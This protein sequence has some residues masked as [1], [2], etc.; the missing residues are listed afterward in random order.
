[1]NDWCQEEGGSHQKQSGETV[2]DPARRMARESL[3]L[4]V[5]SFLFA[6]K[7][8]RDLSRAG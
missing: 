6:H 3:S 8:G 7:Q 5:K 4:K 2:G 1:M